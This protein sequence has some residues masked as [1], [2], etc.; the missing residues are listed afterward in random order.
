MKTRIL[1]IEDN[2]YRYFTAKQVLEAKTR[3]KVDVMTANDS[4]AVRG[5]AENVKPDIIL[6]K[7]KG[8]IMDLLEFMEKRNVN[9][10]NT[11]ISMILVPMS[12]NEEA[13]D[14]RGV[15]RCKSRKARIA[16]AA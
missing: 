10:R 14:L 16:D 5:A 4:D 1:I 8:G 13:I 15:G 2:Y 6:F 12:C 11:E 7:P 3:I 9:R